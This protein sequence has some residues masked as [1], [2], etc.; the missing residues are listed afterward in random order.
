MPH[1]TITLSTTLLNII[2]HI[3]KTPSIL[4]CSILLLNIMTQNIITLST[5]PVYLIVNKNNANNDI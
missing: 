5:I 4:L 1:V 2:P 3:I